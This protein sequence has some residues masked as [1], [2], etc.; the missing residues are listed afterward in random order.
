MNPTILA[1]I[2]QYEQNDE[3]DY[4][5]NEYNAHPQDLRLTLLLLNSTSGWMFIV[6]FSLENCRKSQ[7]SVWRN[8]VS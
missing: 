8:G 4:D 3:D 5:T 7:E 1:S 6:I 2:C